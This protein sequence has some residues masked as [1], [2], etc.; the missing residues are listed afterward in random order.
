MSGENHDHQPDGQGGEGLGDLTSR[1]TARQPVCFPERMLV[2]CG[3]SLRRLFRRTDPLPGWVGAVAFF[4]VFFLIRAGLGYLPG[5]LFPEGRTLM[6]DQSHLAQSLVDAILV[7]SLFLAAAWYSGRLRASLANEVLPLL[8]SREDM[9]F[10]E[11]WLNQFGKG[12]WQVAA[13]LSFG[14][15]MATRQMAGII[16]MAGRIPRVEWV[17]ILPGFLVTSLS[18]IVIAV[19]FQVL[20]LIAGMRRCSFH[21]F[22]DQPASSD[23]IRIVARLADELVY[24]FVFL[25]ITNPL[26]ATLL[27]VG[28]DHNI[29]AGLLA[30]V[31]LVYLVKHATLTGVIQDAKVQRLRELQAQVMEIQTKTQVLST[32][33]LTQVGKLLDLHDRVK[34][35]PSSTLNLRSII[36]LFNQLLIPIV[37]YL[38]SN[39]KNLVEFWEEVLDIFGK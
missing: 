1:L 38:V 34:A 33:Q 39:F 16:T 26:A 3:E 27:G 23:A 8:G 13:G 6:A 14:L 21:L 11:G 7:T 36:A 18:G 29:L 2:V 35:S 4:I 28:F 17:I 20:Q 32:D 31:V 15:V 37:V 9:R 10:V 22:P 19:L 12:S 24:S 25:A 30:P 5:I